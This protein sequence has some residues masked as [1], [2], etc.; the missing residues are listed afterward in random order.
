MSWLI[1]VCGALAAPAVEVAARAELERALA[2]RLPDARPP[3]LVIYDVLDGEVA[4]VFA[5]G[6]ALV[7]R[8]EDDYRLLRAEVRV[9]DPTLD[10]SNFDTFLE[11][12]GVQSRRLPVEDDPLALRREI[13]LATDEAY[14][15]AVEQYARKTAALA[16]DTAPRPPDRAP[17]PPL[18]V[19]VEV[20]APEVR[21][22]DGALLA[23]RVRALTALALEYP[24]VEVGQA[25]ARDWQGRRL[26][27]SSEG[28]RVWRP[29]G[30]T[31]IRVEYTAR[32]DDGSEIHDARWWVART[33][34]ELPPAEVM[35]AE[36]REM[37]EWLVVAAAAP[38]PEDYLGPVLFEGPAAT[39][40]F[41]QLLAGELVGTPPVTS[42]GDGMFR[43]GKA[44][45]A[46][47]GRRLL[48][49]GWSV[50]DDP[51]LPS[52][53]LGA[54]ASDMEG[55]APRRVEL[56]RDGVVRD[57]LMSR[58]PS[59]ERD[60]STGHGRSL[61][62]NRRGA[63][64][65]VVTVTPPRL[66]PERR[67]VRAG[68]RLAAQTG[69]DHLLVVRRIQPPGLIHE[70]DVAFTG[71]GPLSGLTPPYEVHRLYADGRVEP[72]R[73]LV[74]SGV[75]RRTLKD[76]VL[77]GAGEGP[78]DILDGPPG[79]QRF[80]IGPVGGMPATWDV[81]AVLVAEV[82]LTAAGGG[83]ARVLEAPPR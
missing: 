63:V 49:L 62:D 61:G 54:Y 8:S 12:T 51:S 74:F 29:A 19:P 4:E 43:R 72:A 6:G 9:G 53:A 55:V 56:V 33:P 32:L 23:D 28:A 10:S 80:Q 37:A 15:G 50:V 26:L 39:E 22:A 24:A 40:L 1:L 31:V 73:S 75:D 76:I 58:I 64:P 48:P 18:D 57:V 11:R 60:R 35:L 13:W 71:E 30:S 70:V 66:V 69:R 3:Y 16:D 82:E 83:E 52:T 68:L 47:I 67:L 27:L 78:V 46:R 21:P 44:P 14:K 25:I 79:P 65:A 36:V 17:A 45:G 34:A 2:L 81:P 59:K 42:D 38:A 20:G 5:E 77:A 41:V 7:R